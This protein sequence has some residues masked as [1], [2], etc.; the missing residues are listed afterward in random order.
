M[1]FRRV[2]TGTHCRTNGLRINESR[3]L[4][5][6]TSVANPDPGSGAFFTPGS[7]IRDG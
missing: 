7:G 3:N 5:E 2:P 4:K 1:G 6:K